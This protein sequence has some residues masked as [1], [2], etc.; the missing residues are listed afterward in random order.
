MRFKILGF[1]LAVAIGATS[2]C[3]MPVIVRDEGKDPASGALQGAGKGATIGAAFGPWGELAGAA[4]GA[5][6][7]GAG[8]YHVGRRHGRRAE[9]RDRGGIQRDQLEPLK[10]PDVAMQERAGIPAA[11]G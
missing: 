7:G 3:A 11:S 1:M 2:A 4:I 10:R 9:A 8:S 5:I 6:L